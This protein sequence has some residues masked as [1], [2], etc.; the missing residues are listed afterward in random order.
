MDKSVREWAPCPR[1]WGRTLLL[2]GV[3]L[4]W[5]AL[6]MGLGRGRAIQAAL[7]EGG[8]I[9]PRL[10]QELATAQEPVSFLVILADQP[11]P[12]AYLASAGLSRANKEV[13]GRALYRYLTRY[14]L[15]R[16]RS[17][18]AW[19]VG[20]GVSF[21]PFYLVNALEVQGDAR[22][23]WELAV[24]PEVARLVAN[25]QVALERPRVEERHLVAPRGQATIPLPYGIEQTHAPA[26]WDQGYRGQGIVVA[27]QDTG[28]LW[29]HPALKLRYRG[30]DPDTG[31]ASHVYN[32]FDAWGSQG[33][34]AE[35]DPDPQVP[36]DDNGH[37]TH[38]VGT[39]LGH[40][41][42]GAGGEVIVGMAPEAQWI[43][44]RN[45]RQGA[46]TP[47]SY[48]ACFQF[49]LAPYPQGGDPFRDGKP[50][51]APHIINNSWYC[52]PDEGCD[53][54]S[55]AQATAAAAAAGQLVVASAGNAGPNCSTVQY[56]ISAYADVFSVGAHD[57]SGTIASFSSRGPVTADGSGRLKPEITAPG[58]AVFS[59]YNN[60][61]YTFLSGTSMA[62]PHVAGAVAL[63]WSAAPHLI[64]QLDETRRI[65]EAT[66]TPVPTNQ[67]GEGGQPV[68]PN[69]T[70]G[71]GRLDVA[72]AVA[73]ALTPYRYYF[74][75][76]AVERETP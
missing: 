28:V 74:P 56:P 57:S 29:E 58:V 67:C 53:L 30:W 48:M 61:S 26:V 70:Y 46:G 41:P 4:L 17:L 27:S 71:Y 14:A 64:G 9:Q 40:D 13:R 62:S 18:R 32:W 50:E 36:C 45:M 15:T 5:L 69:N 59:T 43:G 19:L 33:R 39:M 35:C 55:L 66:A 38:T 42:N 37:G 20:R 51:L 60:G 68:T 7:P 12:A 1:K 25:P 31:T 65:L 21:R 24:R 54:A 72:R 44:C 2:S 22:L 52:P 6:G 47:A 34:P 11:D 49:F 16:Q 73:F 76:V 10:A 3:L 23:A 63:L 8:R 75:W